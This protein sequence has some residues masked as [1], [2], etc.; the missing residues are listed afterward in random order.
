MTDTTDIITIYQGHANPVTLILD[1]TLEPYPVLE[2]FLI[3]F[4]GLADIDS[5]ETPAAIIWDQDTKELSLILGPHLPEKNWSGAIWII[6]FR[7]DVD[8]GLVWVAP[9]GNAVTRL[10]VQVVYDA[11]TNPE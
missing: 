8:P 6:G 9:K 3:V 1:T 11:S 7:D 5:Y 4:P 2:R 10:T